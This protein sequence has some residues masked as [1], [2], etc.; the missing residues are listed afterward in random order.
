MLFISSISARLALLIVCSFFGIGTPAIALARRVALVIGNGAYQ[1]TSPLANPAYDARTLGSELTRLGFEVEVAQDVDRTNMD[2]SLQRFARKMVGV[3]V[4]LFF[5]AGH[6]L[7]IGS[8]NY[9][10]PVGAK[11]TD[12]TDIGKQ[13]I[14]V[15]RQIESMQNRAKVLLIFLDAC[16][17]NPIAENMKT[18]GQVVGHGLAEMRFG[19]RDILIVYATSPGEVASDGKGL[20]SPFTKAL[21]EHI[22]RRG[23][24][25]QAMLLH[26]TKRVRQLTEYR[27]SPWV[28]GSLDDY[29]YLAG[30]PLSSQSVDAADLNFWNAI[31][32]SKEPADLMDY[33]HRYPGGH[34]VNQAR[35]RYDALAK[36]YSNKTRGSSEE[37]PPQRGGHSRVETVVTP[38]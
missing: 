27:Q 37:Q 21:L 1:Y 4:A 26:V 31:K 29:I 5:Y 15:Q 38:D 19:G 13:L 23:I 24:D 7:Q 33:L 36:E 28:N 10:V 11:L 8:R 3:E 20:N 30:Q 16:R 17:N 32:D 22:G 2:Q 9:L 18:H 34:F 35:R 25:L 14:D 12:V 6:G